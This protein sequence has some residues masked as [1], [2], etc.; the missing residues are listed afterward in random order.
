MQLPILSDILDAV[1]KF[2]NWIWTEVKWI[3]GAIIAIVITPIT[4]ILDFANKAVQTVSGLIDAI[5]SALSGVGIDQV[6][7]HWSGAMTYLS[8]ANTIFPINLSVI[9]FVA[10]GTLW[11]ACA[12]VR[13][14]IRVFTLGLG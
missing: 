6:S 14:C 11:I 7:G 13:L 8:M 5:S 9:L 12:I 1:Q 4:A 2:A 10:L 3:Y